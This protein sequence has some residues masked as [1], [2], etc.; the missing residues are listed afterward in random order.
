M[1]CI[2][3]IDKI[4]IVLNP[5]FINPNKRNI[6]HIDP[7]NRLTLHRAGWFT[8]LAIH[9]E[10]FNMVIDYKMNIALAIYDL[11]KNEIISFPDNMYTLSFIYKNLDWFVLFVQELEFFFDFRPEDIVIDEDELNPNIDGEGK[12]LIKYRS[13]FYSNDYRS[14][15]RHS[16][17]KIYDRETKLKQDRSMKSQDI[18]SHPYKSRLEFRLCRNN[19]EYL[20][21]DDLEGTYVEIIV[22]V[23]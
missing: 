18:S 11:I 6:K 15:K 13:T 20:N 17:L 9:A 16:I 4:K 1:R 12:Q 5:L 7:H 2:E 3:G 23:S 22:I 21:I 8:A 14:G 19:C 10:Y